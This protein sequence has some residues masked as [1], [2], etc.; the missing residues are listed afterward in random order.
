MTTRPRDAH[1]RRV[2]RVGRG[3]VLHYKTVWDYKPLSTLDL[4]MIEELT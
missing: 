1:A 3:R 2:R 4:L